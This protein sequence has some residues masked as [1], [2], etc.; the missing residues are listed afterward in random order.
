MKKI[1]YR[2][3]FLLTAVFIYFPLKA[4]DFH[5][6]FTANING[7]LQNCGCGSEPLGGVGRI[8]T[9][10]D[11]FRKINANTII[12]DGGDY[13]NSYPFI[14]L[15]KTM[16]RALELI[17]YDVFV[18]GDQEFVEGNTFF[19][20][21]K[22]LLGD[23]M[24]ISNKH[25]KN[26]R[27]RT[28]NFNGSSV[29]VGGFISPDAFVFIDSPKILEL[30]ALSFLKKNHL[31]GLNVVVFHGSL[32]EAEKAAE[33]N[34]WIDLILLAHDQYDEVRNISNT[35]IIGCGRNSEFISIIAVSKES[36]GWLFNIKKEKVKTSIRE[37][38]K[39]ATLIKDYESTINK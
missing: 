37:N 31:N 11:E 9:F 22:E 12:I 38:E 17:D 21:I 4:A 36:E 29:H 8:K 10:V 34:E 7:T 39:I 32:L 18:P 13:F 16:L 1:E 3:V 24:L 27:Y 5:I 28:F 6:L 25:S 20:E 15:N 2:I 30:F 35:F 19:E 14:E 23:R 26:I 33:E